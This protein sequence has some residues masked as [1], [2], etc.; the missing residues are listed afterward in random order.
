MEA[1]AAAIAALHVLAP[2]ALYILLICALLVV[3]GPSDDFES[4]QWVI[5]FAV[6]L[7][8]GMVIAGRQAR[9]LDEAHIAWALA[10]GTLAIWAALSLR[11]LGSGDALHHAILAL[12]G[13]GALAAPWLVRRFTAS[14][15][16]AGYA[17]AVIALLVCALMFVPDTAL[18]SNRLVLA[19]VMAGICLAVLQ[20]TAGREP[21]PRLRFALDIVLAGIVG[22]VAMAVPDIRSAGYLLIHHQGFYLGPVNAMMHG[23]PMLDGTWSQYGVGVMDA[24]RAM[25]AVVP[26]GYGGMSLIVTAWTAAQYVLIY[27]TLRL[28]IR[29]Q[30]LVAAI[31]GTAIVSQLLGPDFTAVTLPST[32]ALRF[33]LTYLVIALAVLAA[34][35]PT[36]ARALR[37]LQIV[38]VGV[39]AVWSFEALIYTG[40]AFGLIVIVT[41]LGAGPGAVRR[42]VRTGLIAA[43]AVVGA[44]L[45]YSGWSLA[46]HGNVDWGPYLEYVKLYSLDG[47]SHSPMT[48]ISPGPLMGAA[49]FLSIAGTIHL[50]RS[51]PS[52]ATPEQLVALAGFGGAAVAFYTYYLGSSIPANLRPCLMPIVAVGGLWASLLLQARPAPARIGALGAILLAMAMLAVMD[53]SK[54]KGRWADTAFAQAV[55]YADGKRPGGEGRSIIT[56]AKLL[57]RQP[58]LNARAP[59]GVALLDRHL[60]AGAP[61]LVLTEPDLTTEILVR[62]DRRNLLPTAHPLED[63]LLDSS[64]AL[65]TDAAEHVPAGTLLL[66]STPPNAT[67]PTGPLNP[68]NFVGLELVAL[69]VLHRRFAF[70]IVD[71]TPDGLRLV[72]LKPRA[73]GGAR[74]RP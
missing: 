12:A 35:Y 69:D 1:P 49:I 32:S 66:T 29:S 64:D 34:H 56:S 50:A 16:G 47:F 51:H 18:R 40:A 46:T 58:V 2:A 59:G 74:T 60:P 65:I 7:P 53:W 15:A 36:R 72:R 11:R 26:M 28:A 39:S 24:L 55:P 63:D 45:A 14:N 33:G 25:F 6:A 52:V 13:A 31:V 27:A 8:G 3:L 44:V 9:G 68:A 22:L 10:A 61:A 73:A 30:V 70:V 23:Q 41:E 54:V 37:I 42:V 17:T 4:Q 38:V 57:W 67:A 20:L 21:G 71:R 43:G 19:L 62:A 48:F 5:A